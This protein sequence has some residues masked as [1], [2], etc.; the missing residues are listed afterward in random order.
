[1]CSLTGVLAE[2]DAATA[3]GPRYKLVARNQ[4]LEDVYDLQT[5]PTEQHNLWP[6]LQSDDIA[7]EARELV[8]D[9]EKA[10]AEWLGATRNAAVV[11]GRAQ[12]TQWT[13]IRGGASRPW[14]TCASS[15]RFG[16]CTY[17]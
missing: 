2:V 15:P 16:R 1:M 9:H 3:T 11:L 17:P 7:D 13:L 8:A 4:R 14:A 10:L 5:D 12:T 6:L